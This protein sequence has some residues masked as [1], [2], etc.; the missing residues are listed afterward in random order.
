[1]ESKF[2]PSL[3]SNTTTEFGTENSSEETFSK[4]NVDQ[5]ICVFDETIWNMFCILT[6]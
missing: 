5:K 4:L 1:M 3:Y 2:N 6:S